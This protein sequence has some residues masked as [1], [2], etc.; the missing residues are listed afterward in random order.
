M[1]KEDFNP[2]WEL[3]FVYSG[4]HNIQ[5]W[6]QH[7]D[8]KIPHQVG[9]PAGT[10]PFGDFF[11]AGMGKAIKVP[12]RHIQGWGRGSV[13]PPHRD[14]AYMKVLKYSSIKYMNI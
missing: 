1:L 7:R 6:L 5:H 13:S 2:F 11:A 9:I 14:P 12:P 10:T 3:R 8:V 4:I